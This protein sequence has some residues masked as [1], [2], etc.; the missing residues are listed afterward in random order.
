MAKQKLKRFAEFSSWDNCFDFPYEIKGKWNKDVFKNSHPIVLELGCGKGEY[1]VALA[2]RY[3]DKNYLGVDI[4]SN[5]MWVGAKMAKEENLT[6]IA[7][8]RAIM[9]KID[10]IIGEGEADE[11]WIT[12]PDPFLRSKSA[13]HRLTHT[14]FLRLY[15]KILK[16]GGTIHLK[17]DSDDL[18][19]FTVNMLQHLGI[20]PIALEEDVHGNPDAPEI[21]KEVKTYYERLFMNKGSTIKYISFNLSS[22]SEEQ[23]VVFEE[24]FEQERLR[25]V[26]L[27]LST[28]L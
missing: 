11:I 15:K 6:H 26:A 27:G 7:F 18:F 4:K 5:R 13:K 1:T 2:K 19:T 28:G 22:F 8:M 10:T 9:H 20:K 21:L 25:R 3:P 14:R 17:T 16:P 24:W 12:F 23:A